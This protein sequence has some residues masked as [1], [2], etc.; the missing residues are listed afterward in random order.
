VWPIGGS[1]N[2]KL[3]DDHSTLN[4]QWKWSAP[5]TPTKFTRVIWTRAEPDE[6]ELELHGGKNFD[7]AS[8]ADLQGHWSGTFPPKFGAPLNITLNIAKLPSGTFSATLDSPDQSKFE[9]RAEVFQFK[10]PKVKLEVKAA[11]AAFEGRL[12]DG[13][14]TGDWNFYDTSAPIVF[15]RR[16]P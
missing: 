7:Y 9:M 13:K 8:D 1:F 15:E 6:E 4:G 14:L 12:V 11:H 5:F 10:P 2:G 3:S 16:K